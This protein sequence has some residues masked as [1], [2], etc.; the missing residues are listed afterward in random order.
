[1]GDVEFGILDCGLRIADCGLRNADC[2][3]RI[4]DCGL[5]V[6]LRSINNEGPFETEAHDRQDSWF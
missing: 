4:A 2:G 6:S 3:M 5:L 1:M